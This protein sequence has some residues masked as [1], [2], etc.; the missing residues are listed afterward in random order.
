[1]RQDKTIKKEKNKTALA[2]LLCFSVVTL[3]AIFT[4][5]SSLDKI[6]NMSD[7]TPISPI[8]SALSI[9]SPVNSRIPTVDSQTDS[10]GNTG[11][12]NDNNATD[13]NL[14]SAPVKGL[15]IQ[16]F[17]ADMPVYSKTLD[18]YVVHNGVDIAAIQDT[19]V[20]AIMAGTITRIDNDDKYGNLIEINHGN[21][22]CSIYANLSGTELVE[23]GDVVERGDVISGVGNSSLFE[24]MEECHLHFELLKDG[25]F[26]NPT[27]HIHF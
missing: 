8:N 27:D 24:V 20:C 18:Q 16:S 21:G 6:D 9:D 19:P 26:V 25:E 22:Y 5:K 15:V 10:S 3:F 7:T 23:T 12:N 13:T 4:V 17:S 14:F 2:L 1:M 11:T